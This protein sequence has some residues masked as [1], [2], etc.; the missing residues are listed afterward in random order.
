MFSHAKSLP[1]NPG[2]INPSL[3]RQVRRLELQ[4]DM[5]EGRVAMR[6]LGVGRVFGLLCIGAV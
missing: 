3:V 6:M 4:P 2:L 5:P 1:G